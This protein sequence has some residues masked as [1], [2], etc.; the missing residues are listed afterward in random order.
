MTRRLL[1]VIL[2]LMFCHPF[3]DAQREILDMGAARDFCDSSPLDEIEGIW[4]YV[5]DDVKVLV[6][7][8]TLDDSV[9]DI[10]VVETPDCRLRPGE[11]LGKM[12]VSADPRQFRMSLFTNRSKGGLLS[13]ERECLAVLGKDGESLRIKGKKYKIS[14]RSLYLLPRFWRMVRVVVDNPL[15][16][17][18]RGLVK[19]YPSYDGNGSTRRSPRYL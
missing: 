2:S 16:D 9:Y 5:E 4:Y 18:P 15:D 10:Q 1:I 12:H 11:L 13:D 3:A 14:L 6:R 17:L 8:N 7:R 19:I